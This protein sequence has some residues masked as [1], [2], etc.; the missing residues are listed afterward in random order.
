MKKPTLVTTGLALAFAVAV[1]ATT[2]TAFAGKPFSNP[3]DIAFAN[4]LWK[5]MTSARLV[6]KNSF[7][8]MPYETPPPHGNFVEPM[9][10]MLTVNGRTDIVIVKRNF[11]KR[12]V[13]TK[14]QVANNPNKYMTSITVMFKREKGYDPDNKDWFWAK[15]APGGKLMKNPKG[16]S[17]A[18]RVAKGAPKGCI[19]CHS[20]APGGDMVYI[21]DRYA[22]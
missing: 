10:G 15:Y 18:G 13:T 16:M 4:Q 9:D 8:A 3:E 7:H 20:G 12:G 19:A 11:G 2:G 6:G 21:H 1:T 5:D 22:Q 17:L 14:E